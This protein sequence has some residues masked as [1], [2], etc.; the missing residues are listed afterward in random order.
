M[1]RLA[2]LIPSIVLAVAGATVRTA[3]FLT[4]VGTAFVDLRAQPVPSFSA[5][6]T[7]L[8]RP[9]PAFTR[10]ATITSATAAAADSEAFHMTRSPL[11]AVLLSAAVPGLGQAYLGQYWKLPILYGL[12]GAF[13]YGE[14]IQNT[15]Y[16]YTSDTIAHA[17]ARMNARD[18]LW[19]LQ[20]VPVREFYRDDR[21]KFWIYLGLTYIAN[22]LDAYIAANLYDFDVSDPVPTGA[23]RNTSH[24]GAYYDPGHQHYEVM[25]P[26]RF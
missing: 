7:S 20:N 19:A 23:P 13:F 9:M 12:I 1:H 22:I 25:L 11:E 2:R 21:D 10:S 16:H 18:T 17:Y 5:Q 24:L 3:L 8:D 26:T 6:S 14:Q 15:R 4:L